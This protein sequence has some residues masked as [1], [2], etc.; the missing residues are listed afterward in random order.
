MIPLA[1]IERMLQGLTA[2]ADRKRADEELRAAADRLTESAP[3]RYSKMGRI[4]DELHR[5]Y[6][7]APDP[8]NETIGPMPLPEGSVMDV[9][10]ACLFVA[11]LATSIG[12]PCRFVAARYGRNWTLFLTYQDE[13]GRWEA[14]DPLRQRTSVRL[15][16][17]MIVR[18]Q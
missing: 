18:P 5:R 3:D 1:E 7:Y 15:D 10:D 11:V 13:E 17:L 4:V 16:E 12:I 14:V 9:D 6:V 2:F 8:V